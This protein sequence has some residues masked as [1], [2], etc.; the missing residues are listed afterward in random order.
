MAFWL[1]VMMASGDDGLLGFGD[2]AS[3]N[4]DGFW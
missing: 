3:G 2:D 1:L 4:G